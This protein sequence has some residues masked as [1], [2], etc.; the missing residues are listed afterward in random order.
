MTVDPELTSLL[1]RD[2]AQVAQANPLCGPGL[3]GDLRGDCLL[4]TGGTGFVGTWMA[5]MVAYLNDCHDFGIQ[6]ILASDNARDFEGRAPHLASRADITLLEQDAR[7]M[8]ELPAQVNWIVHAAGSPDNRVHASDPLRTFHVIVQGTDAV[9][10][11]ATRLP[12]LKRFL[13]LSSG[14]VYGAQP[15]TLDAMPETFRGTLSSNPVTGLY[16]EAKRAAETLCSAYRTQH[17]LSIVNARP[18]AF[19]GPYQLLN[20]PWAINNFIRDAILGV[21]IRI[22]GDGET[23]RSYMYPSDMAWWFFHILVR[24][25]SGLSY[26]VGSS[27]AVTLNQ[28]AEQIASNLAAPPKILLKTAGDAHLRQ[29]RF[30]PDTTLAQQTLQLSIQVELTTALKRTISWNRKIQ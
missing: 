7:N 23:V 15:L 28:L 22:M 14:L 26:N 25:E 16:A 1:Q 21:P 29:S 11:A 20:R 2:C 3:L 18:F 5:E 30:V 10:A 19:V 27:H 12:N 24:G 9:L 8:Q 6:L 13:N 17:R 4:I